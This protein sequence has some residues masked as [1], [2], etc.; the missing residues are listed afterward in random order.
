MVLASRAAHALGDVSVRSVR[1]EPA[2]ARLNGDNSP[3]G[4]GTEVIVPTSD[5]DLSHRRGLFD[6][7]V[8]G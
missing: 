6:K 1:A 7:I 5:A 2:A 4:S 3:S 8:S